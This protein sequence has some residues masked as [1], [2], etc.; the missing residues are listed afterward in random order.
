[1]NSKELNNRIMASESFLI[2]ND[3]QYLGKL[4]LNRYNAESISNDYGSYGIVLLFK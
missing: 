4:T 2:A 1:M 3:G